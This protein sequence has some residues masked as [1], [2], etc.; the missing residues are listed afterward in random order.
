MAS[1][2]T[3]IN[4]RIQCY[5]C[6]GYGHLTSQCPSQTKTLLVEVPIDVK[7]DGLKVIVH[8]QHDDSDASAEECECNG[9]I[10][11]LAVTNLLVMT[12][13]VSS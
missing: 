8:Q 6:Q 2:P 11:T 1:E 3:K 13:P 5:R 9:S 12:S 10:R 4:P 7:E